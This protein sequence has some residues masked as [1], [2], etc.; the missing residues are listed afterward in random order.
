MHENLNPIIHELL[1]HKIKIVGI[2]KDNASVNKK[3]YELLKK[4]H[5]QLI[6]IPCS[7][8][9]I[10][11]CIHKILELNGTVETITWMN[12]LSDTFRKNIGHQ[13]QLRNAQVINTPSIL[14]SDTSENIQAKNTNQNQN[15]N[16][17][18]DISP[19]NIAHNNINATTN[20]NTQST[21]IPLK[22]VRPTDTR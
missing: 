17:E 20:T 6:N 4:E 9:L 18:S 22:L 14:I 7:A 13:L 2:V 15:S 21:N 11:L 16:S 19:I 8:H 12:N 5:S 3:L 10:Q 1:G